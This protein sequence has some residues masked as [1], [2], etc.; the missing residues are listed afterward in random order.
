[1]EEAREVRQQVLELL[2]TTTPRWN[3]CTVGKHRSTGWCATVMMTS[4]RVLAQ[5]ETHPQVFRLVR[6]S[7]DVEAAKSAGQLAV[8]MGIQGASHWLRGNWI[9]PSCCIG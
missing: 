4:E 8:L 3:G 9:W 6:S 7:G 2:A 5:L 1:M